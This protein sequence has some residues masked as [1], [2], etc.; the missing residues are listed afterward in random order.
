MTDS[1]KRDI[2]LFFEAHASYHIRENGKTR[3]YM[4]G[5]SDDR[6]IAFR[7][8]WFAL[9]ERAYFF[10]RSEKFRVEDDTLTFYYHESVFGRD[11]SF[12]ITITRSEPL[13]CRESGAIAPEQAFAVP[14]L[15]RDGRIK[16]DECRYNG[17]R[18]FIAD[19]FS[20]GMPDR[21]YSVRIKRPQSAAI[22]EK[23]IIHGILCRHAFDDTVTLYISEDKSFFGL[24]SVD[25]SRP[26][27]RLPF[28]RQADAAP[29]N[30]CTPKRQS[31]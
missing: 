1:Q 30:P 16:L 2:K 11:E 22:F 29:C 6:C 23:R 15:L 26:L 25:R 8:D 3:L 31:P 13:C 20:I 19:L 5:R 12:R 24:W 14:E 17:S 18:Y 4:R 10:S 28:F 21:A 27:S 7:Q 9:D